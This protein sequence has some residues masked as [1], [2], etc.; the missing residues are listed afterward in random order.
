MEADNEN[1]VKGNKG[2]GFSGDR[3]NDDE[4]SSEA[5][6]EETKSCSVGYALFF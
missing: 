4:R 2:V 3:F 6:S 1:A 5:E